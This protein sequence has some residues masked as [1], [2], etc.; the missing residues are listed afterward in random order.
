[1]T[2]CPICQKPVDP[3]R[4][5]AVRVR[6]GKVTAYC[7]KEHAELA[8]TKPTAKIEPSAALSK[9][10]AKG[11][12]E[13]KGTPAKGVPE[14]KSKADTKTPAK[15]VPKTAQTPSGGIP[16]GLGSLESGPVIEIV[17]EPATGVVTS[18]ADARLGGR[19]HSASRSDVD[20]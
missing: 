9:T 17:H 14:T 4:A 15:G 7:S 2:P 11:V 5:T 12:P 10:P 13:T 18:A 3:L 19:P 6:N 8:D 1:M 16:R 20:G